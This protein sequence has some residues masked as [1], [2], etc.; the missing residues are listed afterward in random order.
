MGSR[1]KIPFFNNKKS[2]FKNEGSITFGN[3]NFQKVDFGN[4]FNRPTPK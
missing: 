3:K 2:S 4:C 1:G